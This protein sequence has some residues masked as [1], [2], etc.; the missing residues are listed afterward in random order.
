[1]RADARLLHALRALLLPLMLVFASPVQA[2]PA[3]CGHQAITAPV[4]RHAD[5]RTHRHVATD[6]CG[7]SAGCCAGCTA[8]WV[9]P[10]AP[11]LP[12]T[13]R[14]LRVRFAPMPRDRSSGRNA[15]PDQKPPRLDR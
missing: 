9:V 12:G 8:N 15:P 1:M 4:L 2:A 13:A 3:E 6:H 5:L 14:V 7:H 10:P 11:L